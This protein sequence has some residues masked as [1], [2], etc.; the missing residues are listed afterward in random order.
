MRQ[1]QGVCFDGL[2]VLVNISAADYRSISRDTKLK[3]S[4]ES[5]SVRLGTR[6]G[7]DMLWASLR[8]L[9]VRIGVRLN[10]PIQ[11]EQAILS[12]VP[13]IPDAYFSRDIFDR[14]Q[15][16]NLADDVCARM[17]CRNDEV[18]FVARASNAHAR[19]AQGFLSVLVV[20]D[21][22]DALSSRS[23][24][25][26]KLELPAPVFDFVQQLREVN[27]GP[28]RFAFD[29][30]AR[31]AVG[32]QSRRSSISSR[33]RDSCDAMVPRL[34]PQPKPKEGNKRTAI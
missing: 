29:V 23:V 16:G 26:G 9:E 20:E 18:L 5:L 12:Y 1:V 4:G 33:G 6:P 3:C 10:A 2:G 11:Y 19:T 25:A 14:S 34:L 13:G 15:T 22:L 17:L 21:F 32:S 24:K 7:T 27:E 30:R 31:G 28:F 8:R